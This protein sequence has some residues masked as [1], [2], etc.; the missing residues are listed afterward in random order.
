MLSIHSTSSTSADLM[1]N[2][3]EIYLIC[4]YQLMVVRVYLTLFFYLYCLILIIIV[5]HFILVAIRH[6]FSFSL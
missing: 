3:E 2:L 4:H 1:S 5:F 6:L